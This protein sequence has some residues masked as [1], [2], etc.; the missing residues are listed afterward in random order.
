M[1]FTELYVENCVENVKKSGVF[2][3]QTRDNSGF[4]T[5]SHG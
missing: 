5:K 4:Y 1:T 3:P 2:Q